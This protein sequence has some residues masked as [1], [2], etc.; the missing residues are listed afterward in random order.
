VL[1]PVPVHIMKC[2]QLNMMYPRNMGNI[3]ANYT[4]Q[5]Q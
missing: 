4:V 5:Q 3:S 1:F 2:S